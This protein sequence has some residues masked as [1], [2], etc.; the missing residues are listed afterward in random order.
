MSIVDTA[1]FCDPV[2]SN[3]NQNDRNV[4][5]KEENQNSSSGINRIEHMTPDIFLEI[6]ENLD[7][8]WQIKQLAITSK[9]LY[10]MVCSRGWNDKIYKLRKVWELR[11]LMNY[12]FNESYNFRAIAIAYTRT[13]PRGLED[14]LTIKLMDINP[15]ES[16]WRIGKLSN[17]DSF[18]KGEGV[19]QVNPRILRPISGIMGGINAI[20]E[21]ISDLVIPK[22]LAP[23]NRPMDVNPIR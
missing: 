15:E 2:M 18:W 16:C 9:P 8:L 14:V 7:N 23:F 17:L 19:I 20:G 11:E 10:A 5:N 21:W 13:G 12:R 6:G 3:S 1:S 4:V 22:I